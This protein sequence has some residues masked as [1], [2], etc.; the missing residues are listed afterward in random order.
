MKYLKILYI[1]LVCLTSFTR[2]EKKV[3]FFSSPDPKSEK[4]N[5]ENQ[6]KKPGIIAR[7]G[8]PFKKKNHFE[9]K[10]KIYIKKYNFYEKL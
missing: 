6:L 5:P 2:Y 7:I 1:L 4:K 10:K 3:F 8:L 9:S